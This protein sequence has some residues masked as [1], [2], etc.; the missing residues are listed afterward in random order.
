MPVRANALHELAG[1]LSRVHKLPRLENIKLTF[2]PLY[3]RQLGFHDRGRL[4]VQA[5]ILSALAT[6][7]S[8][9]VPPKLTSL[10]LDSLPI[11]KLSPFKS[12]SF[13]AVLTSLRRLL[14]ST[15]DT[16]WRHFWGTLCPRMILAPTQHTL[17][18][19]TLHS[20]APVGTSSG[21]SP[22]GLH[23]PCLS[24]LSLRGVF[25]QPSVG[26]EPFVLRH[27]ATLARLKV[28]AC[29]LPRPTDPSFFDFPSL[30]TALT[31]MKESRPG[32]GGW[33]RIWDRFAAELTALVTL[34]VDTQCRYIDPRSF[35]EVFVLNS[36]YAADA[37]ALRRFRMTVAARS[38]ETRWEF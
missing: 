35:W 3:D 15:S 33:D 23:F 37:A 8:I 20:D 22:A 30:S 12:P 29:K 25:F 14:L 28:F 1:S 9:C 18:D 13:Q 31:Q 10:S 6:S 24:A 26:A 21:F 34:D 27:A 4:G 16:R 5:S 38:G 11:W 7:F 19:P 36:R 17:T 2:Y 32:P